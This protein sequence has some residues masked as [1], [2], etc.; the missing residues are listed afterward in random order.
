MQKPNYYLETSIDGEWHFF[1]SIS[2]KKII[3]KGILFKLIDEETGL[4]ELIFGDLEDGVLNVKIKSNNDDMPKIIST[5]IKSIYLFFEKNP[6]KTVSFLGSSES[7]TRLYKIIISK[8]FDQLSERFDIFG[9]NFDGLDEPFEKN[10]SYFA[11]K[12]KLKNDNNS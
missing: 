2:E 9:I 4:F 7:R 8:Y 1:K 12:I 11:Y 10:T 3:E 6:T 5:V